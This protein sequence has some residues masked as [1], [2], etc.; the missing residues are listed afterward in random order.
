MGM[1]FDR[2]FVINLDHRPE[3]WQRFLA[4]YPR[5]LPTPIRWRAS[6]PDAPAPPAWWQS[7]REYYACTHSHISL[8]RHCIKE[9]IESCLI[10]EDD[11]VPAGDFVVAEY[12]AFCAELPEQ[13]SWVY[14]GGASEGLPRKVSEHVYRPLWVRDAHAYGIS[15]PMMQRALDWLDAESSYT[16]FHS[17]DVAYMALHAIE[18]I[19]APRRWL[20]NQRP[21]YSDNA[22]QDLPGRSSRDLRDLK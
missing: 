22:L 16:G 14:L 4:D 8:L 5:A 20:F 10:F 6:L 3:R 13:A 9:G 7:S 21:G 2:A 17:G 1:T 19:Y 15:R 12:N 18:D 11:A